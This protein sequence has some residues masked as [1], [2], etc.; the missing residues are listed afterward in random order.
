ML[1]I[2]Q[3]AKNA[4]LAPSRYIKFKIEVYFDG[5]DNPPTDI[6][7]DVISFDTVEEVSPS[8]TLP[9]GGVSYNELSVVFD[10]MQQLYTISNTSSMYNGKL[11]AN[12]K[13]RL[14]YQVEVEEDVFEEITGGVFYTDAWSSD[15]EAL[16]ATLT[17]YD[18]LALYGNKPVSRFKV[19]RN[20]SFKAAYNILLQSVGLTSND[21]KIS[22]NLSGTID[23]FWATGDSL[24]QCLDSLS[25]LTLSNVFVD[26]KGII[27]IVPVVSNDTS[28]LTLSDDNLILT[29]RSTPSYSNVYSGAR[30]KYN[31]QSSD[32][33]KQLI[34]TSMTVE[35]GINTFDNLIFSSSPVI[36]ITNI[37]MLSEVGVTVD[38]YKYDD[39]CMS[40]T[41]SN[42]TDKPQN[43]K[44]DIKGIVI[45]ELQTT[46]Y[47]E[48]NS[49]TNN[50]IDI[51]LP[52]ICTNAY[53][54][55][56]A[57]YV[58]DMFSNYVS[59]VELTIRGYPPMELADKV[60]IISPTA[61]VDD[62]MSITKISSSMVDG[63]S[64]TIMARRL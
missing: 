4:L 46:L 19:R 5:E 44:L 2:S 60:N 15:N 35:P 43:V 64:S 54:T 62:Y 11:I 59:T 27:S 48:N 12:K 52:M 57:K 37:S 20:I 34:S 38:T 51:E 30:V 3:K 53:A 45:S 47:V 56:Y 10:N 26:R 42:S 61:S 14:T 55:N 21:Y 18:K 1:N 63:L 13:V 29:S 36:Y 16:T 32:E 23:Y 8:T 7:H 31:L 25:V 40:I 58:L 9:F 17:C 22:N 24:N 49:D 50:I 39:K 28:S 33:Q 41:I 6:T